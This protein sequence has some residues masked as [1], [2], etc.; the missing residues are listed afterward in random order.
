[1][2]RRNSLVATTILLIASTG[3]GGSLPDAVQTDG[4]A[5][6]DPTAAMFPDGV[7]HDFGKVPRGPHARHAFRIVNTSSVP[8]QVVSLRV[9]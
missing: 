6:I 5:L 7:A 4:T 9:G 8:L 1:M 3:N 2:F